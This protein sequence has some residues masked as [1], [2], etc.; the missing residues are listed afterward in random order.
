MAESL[1]FTIFICTH[2]KRWR[3]F[4]LLCVAA[5]DRFLNAVAC[6]ALGALG[7]KGNV[8]LCLESEMGLHASQ[9]VSSHPSTLFTPLLPLHL[10]VLPPFPQSSLYVIPAHVN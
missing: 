8:A 1:V 9:H 2:R 3:R 7:E 6:S 10:T 5:S 4:S